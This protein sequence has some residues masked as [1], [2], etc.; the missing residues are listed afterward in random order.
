[1]ISIENIPDELKKSDC[2]VCAR[3]GSKVPYN[4]QTGNPASCSDKETWSTFFLA[5]DCVRKGWYDGV[6]YCFSNNGIVGIDIDDGFDSDGF[7]T[8]TAA[9]IIDTL[10]SYTE[11]SRSGRG[12]HIFV[13]GKLPFKGRNNQN[14]VE[15]YQDGR[16]FIT[17]G[18]TMFYK[19]II[20]NQEGLNRVVE[21]FF[22]ETV[23][24]AHA[25]NKRKAMYAPTFE[26]VNGSSIPLKARYEDIPQGSRNQC[27]ASL[28][29]QLMNA[30]LID[31][32]VYKELM[33]VNQSHCKPPL[34]TY[35]VKQIVNSMRRY[36][37]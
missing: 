34:P 8:R 2:W 5:H 12:F 29:G 10:H 21:E 17:T 14:G 36:R 37:R 27:L 32:A 31:E 15:A 9:V 6:G 7:I 1:M 25:Y 33:L 30:G 28:C 3:K 13:K 18:N 22:P 24:A 23:R 16:Y 20:E 35:E 19:D 4:P 26:P 11:R